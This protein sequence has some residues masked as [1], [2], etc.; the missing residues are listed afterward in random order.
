[1]KKIFTLTLF[2]LPLFTFSQ[3]VSKTDTLKKVIVVKTND[4]ELSDEYKERPFKGKEETIVID[5]FIGLTDHE[6][7]NLKLKMIARK[8]LKKSK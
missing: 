7:Y 5:S 1:M 8:E 6:I 4:D 2:I 3:T